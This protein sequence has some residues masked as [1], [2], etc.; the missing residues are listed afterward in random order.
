MKLLLCC[1]L[2]LTAVSQAASPPLQVWDGTPLVTRVQTLHVR[3]VPMLARLIQINEHLMGCGLVSGGC[4]VGPR[5]SFWMQSGWVQSGDQARNCSLWY[6]AIQAMQAPNPKP[7]P[8]LE[9]VTRP[10]QIWTDEGLWVYP[11]GSVTCNGA[12]DWN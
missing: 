2:L 11:L 3:G 12:L 7:Y 6:S 5:L 4:S 8:Y 10:G 9:L 1:L